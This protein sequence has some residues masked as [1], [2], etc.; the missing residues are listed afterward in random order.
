[1]IRI[2]IFLI[3]IS[4][5]GYSATDSHLTGQVKSVTHNTPIICPDY[6]DVDLSLGIMRNGVGSMSTTEAVLTIARPEDVRF[7]EKAA[8]SGLPVTI[9]YRFKRWTWCWERGIVDRAEYAE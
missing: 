1:M 2:A 8:Q 5:C 9:T 6:D 4:G 7:L 3:F